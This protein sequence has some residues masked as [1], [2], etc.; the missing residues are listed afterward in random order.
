[1]QTSRKRIYAPKPY[2]QTT[3]KRRAVSVRKQLM[4]FKETRRLVRAATVT[5]YA[6]G[7]TYTQMVTNWANLN[8]ELQGDSGLLT[9]MKVRVITAALS[10]ISNYVRVVVL[11]GK[12]NQPIDASSKIWL[13]ANQFQGA[14]AD[15]TEVLTLEQYVAPF[16]LDGFVVK[17]D[18]VFAVS[19]NDEGPSVFHA[20]QFI[21]MNEKIQLLD[22]T[23][24]ADP[25]YHIAIFNHEADGTAG[26]CRVDVQVEMLYKDLI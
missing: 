12:R 20:E 9:G 3:T 8:D 16:N 18:K 22:D 2:T 15:S 23:S 21:K 26:T 4:K 11:K 7:G 17:Y 19:G 5:T 25:N 10:G 14:P 24:A 6:A 1:M 13:D